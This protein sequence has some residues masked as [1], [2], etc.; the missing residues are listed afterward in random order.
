MASLLSAAS[1]FLCTHC[2]GEVSITVLCVDSSGVNSHWSLD[3]LADERLNIQ[4]DNGQTV[5]DNRTFTTTFMVTSQK[6]SHNLSSNQTR[7][8]SPNFCSN[9]PNTARTCQWPPHSLLLH[10][11]L[12]QCRTNERKSNMLPKA[13]TSDAQFQL[14]HA[15]NFQSGHRK[16]PLLYHK[17]FPLL[18][19]PLSFCQMQVMVV[20]SLAS[21]K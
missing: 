18:C 9:W 19:L 4:M 15:N 2:F 8:Q 14:P 16:L 21:S 11:N 12:F 20:D 13:T 7:K 3:D 17:G 1:Q 6:P 10:P 5:H